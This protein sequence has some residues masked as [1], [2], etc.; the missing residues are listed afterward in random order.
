[1]DGSALPAI[2]ALLDRNAISEA[3]RAAGYRGSDFVQCPIKAQCTAGPKQRRIT[4]W[5]H[6]EVVA[7]SRSAGD[8]L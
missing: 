3:P 6:E 7:R 1:M 5:A 4:R 8:P 2:D